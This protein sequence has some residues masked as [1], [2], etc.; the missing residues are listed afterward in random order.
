[1]SATAAAAAC[2]TERTSWVPSPPG[3]EM[4]GESV[5]SSAGLDDPLAT[6]LPASGQNFQARPLLITE[7]S[8]AE[9]MLDR[10][11]AFFATHGV[12]PRLLPSAALGRHYRLIR[13]GA[14]LLDQVMNQMMR[15]RGRSRAG[16]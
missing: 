16:G 12:A 7:R 15:W 6:Q 13:P 14:C 9:A 3:L 8:L 2:A 11:V 1:V 10:T 5:G 4:V